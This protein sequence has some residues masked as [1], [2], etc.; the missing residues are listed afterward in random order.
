MPPKGQTFFLADVIAMCRRG[1]TEDII[2]ADLKARGCPKA[3]VSQ[4]IRDA[5]LKG[6][7][8]AAS[9]AKPPGRRRG[10]PADGDLEDKPESD[11]EAAGDPVV[12]EQPEAPARREVLWFGDVVMEVDEEVIAA[13]GTATPVL[14][15]KG[16][17]TPVSEYDGCEAGDS[18][19]EIPDAVALQ[20]MAEVALEHSVLESGVERYFDVEPGV[21]DG[22]ESS[23]TEGMASD[24]D[25]HGNVEGLIDDGGPMAVDSDAEA[26]P[27]PDPHPEPR[28]RR[29]ITGKRAASG[30]EI[31][32]RRSVRPA[33]PAAAPM[34]RPAARALASHPGRGCPGQV[35]EQ[36]DCVFSTKDPGQA[37]Y[38]GTKGCCMFCSEETMRQALSTPRGRGNVSQA[39]RAFAEANRQDI[40]DAAMGR[41]P[42]DAEREKF[43]KALRRRK[44]RRQSGD[45][46]MGKDEED[47]MRK[48]Q[49]EPRRNRILEA[50]KRKQQETVKHKQQEELL[51]NRVSVTPKAT[52]AQREEYE[53][54][55]RDDVRRFRNKFKPAHE[56]RARGDDAWRS[57]TAVKLEQ[58]CRE[59]AW[60]Q[61]EQCKRME[62][63]PLRP[64]D[65]QGQPRTWTV[66]KCKHCKSDVGYPTVSIED[67]PEVLRDLPADVLWALRP[68]EPFTGQYVRA[69]HGYRVHTDMIRFWWRPSPVTEQI[70]QLKHREQRRRA[71]EAYQHLMSSESSSYKKW[72]ELH[73]AFRRKHKD[74][75]TGA[76]EDMRLQLP[77]RAMEEEGLECAVWP[78]LYPRTNMCETRV[79]L[80][81]VRRQEKKK[82]RRQG[83]SS[84]SS[85]SNSDSDEQST[86]DEVAG[87]RDPGDFAKKQRNSAKA[88]FLAKVLGP[89]I[90]YGSDTDLVQFV[91]DLWL[92][93]SLGSK[94]NALSGQIPMRL[95][96][97]GHS[98]TPEYWKLRHDALIDAV[99]QL[100]LP[101]L[102]I[103]VSPYEWS[104]PYA[105]WVEDEMAKE[106]RSKTHL[107]VAETLHI[108]HVLGQTI[109]GFL[110]GANNL[111]KN[112]NTKNKKGWEKHVFGA[113]DGSGKNTVR[114]HFARAE[115]QDGKRK[116]YVGE[117]EAASQ[118]YHGRGTVHVH[119]LVWLENEASIGLQES[120]A[121]TSPSDTPELRS[122]VEGSQRSYTGSGWPVREAPSTFDEEAGVLRLHHTKAD[123]M[124]RNKK[125][126]PEGVRAYIKDVLSALY[127]HVDV[128]G[129]D[130]KAGML[131]RYVTSY[132]PKFS[133]SFCDE[134]LAD[135][136]SDYSIARRVLT[137][138]RPLEPEMVLQLAMQ[139]FP[140]TF[141]SG[142]FRK[143][144]VP[145]PWEK[146]ELPGIVRAY[147][148]STWRGKQ[149]SLME[150]LRKANADGNIQQWVRRQH[151]KHLEETEE[152]S[153]ERTDDL[154]EFARKIQPK[155]DTLIAAS[156]LSRYG[157]RYYGQWVLLHV[158]FRSLD[159]LWRPELD[160]VPDHLRYQALAFLHR[161]EIWRQ[162]DRIRETLE[163]EA[164]REHHIANI[165]AML[166][167]HAA[168]IDKYLSGEISKDDYAVEHYEQGVEGDREI[169]VPT[170]EQ[171]NVTNTIVN[172]VRVNMEAKA[173]TEDDWRG[174]AEAGDRAS[175]DEDGEWQ[176]GVDEMKA[177]LNWHCPERRAIA[178]LGPAGSGKTT[179]VEHAVND[180][181]ANGARV[182]IVAPT[183]RLA[184]TYR[185]KYPDLDVDTI[186]GAFLLFKPEQ[187]TLEL[188]IPYDLVIV[189]EV[190]ELPRWVYERL[191]T[192]W[193]AAEMYP[194]LVF[195]GDFFQLPG[196]EQTSARDSPLWHSACMQRI[197]LREMIRCKC[198]LLRKKLEILRVAKPSVKQLR[199]ILKGHKAPSGA[200]Y[201][202]TAEGPGQEEVSQILAETPQT[203]FLTVSRK[204]CA[205]LNDFAVQ[206]LFSEEIPVAVLPTDPESNVENYDGAKFIDDKPLATPIFA[207]MR[208]VLTKNLNKAAGYVN[209]MGA[210]VLGME[211]DAV[212]VR[213]DQGRVVSVYPWTSETHTV[214]YP[215][216]LGYASTL[217]KVQGATLQHITLWLDIA[218]MPAAA[219]VAL[220]RVRHDA[221]W[222]I[223]GHRTVHH[224]T[225]A[226]G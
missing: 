138:Y 64:I 163:L 118:F 70:A 34:K 2:R 106:L 213:T 47:E 20:N 44:T 132:V 206:S 197:K 62:K 166:H 73:D 29:R 107:P 169:Y 109:E 187:Q 69:Q 172:R 59:G 200:Y 68:L 173:A 6:A 87:P 150:Y 5:R 120:I 204:A 184:A 38:R 22:G 139:W 90:G 114:A 75:L 160:R 155:G 131:L 23:E 127:C 147:M 189:E 215:L 86:D 105:Q 148:S 216:R 79:R 119:L 30:V 198:S 162:A 28:P 19:D 177:V 60:V 193:R 111:K 205:T 91:Y 80:S 128:L 221:D 71:R 99:K 83:S 199:F 89:V 202:D 116:R 16:G 219:Y 14:A 225:P 144:V 58:W 37:A 153:A 42:S 201:D 167:A 135:Q 181:V 149:M 117:Q 188:M 48:Q 78:H 27:P 82:R 208:V 137:D 13:G 88:S 43:Q 207:G 102:F 100:G 8:P 212:C 190:G 159:D 101:S 10:A 140:Q 146:A 161:P 156:Y 15:D 84:E 57:E 175:D 209:G 77:R 130:D 218:G 104:F 152:G 136:A 3:R 133:D 182:L 123:H 211:G 25:E 96:A 194:T 51:R 95:A 11:K 192:L 170:T 97:G 203:L 214:H 92:W 196:V 93:S 31:E 53:E 18:E 151:K 171:A 195:L 7:L 224:F 222:R 4:L 85:E 36:R 66:K 56:A 122:L 179:A 50:E 158:P 168:L 41:L 33:V 126:E 76:A 223:V 81:D 94:R 55:V 45:A 129:T 74:V 72:V 185:A 24:V 124:K 110:T 180:C 21:D 174:G 154:E 178:V 191:M 125:N 112:S 157:D 103:T 186:H 121:A 35:A 65:I 12:A 46:E 52:E 17:E 217:H 164:F 1:I 134:W 63:R 220:S 176:R 143:F 210:E 183:G 26:L 165:I 98:F 32:E 115:F 108:A 9:A 226:R 67:I 49:G 142:S 39:L 54:H 61:C 145:V 113:K 141:S 40:F